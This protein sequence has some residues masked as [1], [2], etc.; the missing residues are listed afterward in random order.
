MEALRTKGAALLLCLL[1]I[2]GS[3]LAGTGASLHR[4]RRQAQDVF[5][6]GSG[7]S[8]KGVSYDLREL[9]AQSYN[10]AVM[11]QRYLP[12]SDPSIAD[13]LD[14]R[15]ALTG[16]SRP[17]E[18]YLAAQELALSAKLLAGTLE[19]MGIKWEDQTL[20]QKTLINIDNTL[21]LLAGND[22][23]AAATYFNQVLGSFPANL[24]G[25][26]TGARP[27]ELYE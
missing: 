19:S 12:E 10:V 16:A 5:L 8:G 15:E 17:A 20:L 22:Y 14:R 11:A 24:L 25:P 27:L 4:L 13:V 26:V 21:G 23:N 1:M 9:A 18:Q 6:L 2:A 7:G 3:C